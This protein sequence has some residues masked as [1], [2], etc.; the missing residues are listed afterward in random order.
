MFSRQFH[1]K[2]RAGNKKYFAQ[3]LNVQR[4][5]VGTQQRCRDNVTLFSGHAIVGYFVVSVFVV[6]TP[7][8]VDAEIFTFFVIF[9]VNE[10]V[11]RC[12]VV[13]IACPALVKKEFINKPL[14]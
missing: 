6:H 4:A 1:D 7:F 3:D 13:C 10:A 14:Q 11:L 2:L 5:V 12:R 8:T 9:L